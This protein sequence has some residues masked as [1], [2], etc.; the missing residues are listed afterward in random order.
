[1]RYLR[2]KDSEDLVRDTESSA[3]LNTDDAGLRAYRDR[4]RREAAVSRVI[5]E[6][7][8]IKDELREIKAL[9]TQII[10]QR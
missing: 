3:I 5:E 1:M 6:H 10:G 7:E 8:S 9:L 4:K 2:V